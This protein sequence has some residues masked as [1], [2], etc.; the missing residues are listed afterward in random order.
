MTPASGQNNGAVIDNLTEAVLGNYCNGGGGGD[1]GGDGTDL[2]L[3]MQP[4]VITEL[5]GD[6]LI[7]G[8]GPDEMEMGIVNES[9]GP[10][11]ASETETIAATATPTGS[12]K[13]QP[14]TT[15]MITGHCS[16]VI[17]GSGPNST[18][19]EVNHQLITTKL[20]KKA[21]SCQSNS[22]FYV[23]V[24]DSGSSSSAATNLLDE[25]VN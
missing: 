12:I 14:M 10:I 25:D 3:V 17:R 7:I 16:P 20:K 4:T 9:K 22:T 23:P 18:V 11:A 8:T 15:T 24:T 5:D 19:P 1:G 2:H 21:T 13:A 6:R